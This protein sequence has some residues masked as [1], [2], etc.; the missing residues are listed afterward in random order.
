M[1]VAVERYLANI[2]P[3][4]VLRQA[5][6][7]FS[8][9]RVIASAS[10]IS[11][12]DVD[13]WEAGGSLTY[14]SLAEAHE[15]FS[16]SALDTS[17]GTGARTIL[18]E[19]LNST[20]AEISEIVALAGATPVLLV[21]SYLR[22]NSIK[23]LTSGSLGFAQGTITLRAVTGAVVKA[24]I[25]P[26]LANGASL[27]SQYTVPA[28]KT[29]YIMGVKYSSDLGVTKFSL[30]TRPLGQVFYAVDKFQTDLTAV[31]PPFFSPIPV[32]EKTDIKI[33]ARRANG[34][35]SIVYVNY[36]MLIGPKSLSAIRSFAQ[37]AI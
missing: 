24:V 12:T 33:M 14:S 13:V 17:A 28:N 18:V 6:F 7:G 30:L 11:A 25:S 9:Q 21:N 8:L 3:I 34:P 4:A 15:I 32:E 5:P 26:G 10:S 20:Y 19:G 31:T 2:V 27:N 23:V 16:S 29:A 35:S 1:P 36:D 37:P 22:I